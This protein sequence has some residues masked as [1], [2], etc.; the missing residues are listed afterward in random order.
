MHLKLA[1]TTM[2][3]IA[4]VHSSKIPAASPKI[5]SRL[6]VTPEE[7][8][9]IV[10]ELEHAQ[11]LKELEVLI[12][13]LDDDQLDNLEKILVEDEEDTEDTEFGRVKQ[14]LLDMG[15][16][17]QDIEDLKTLAA[18]MVEFLEKIPNIESKLELKAEADLLDN[19]QVIS[20]IQIIQSHES[21]QLYL[22]GLPNKLGPLGF[23]A[24][25]HVLDGADEEEE[26][27]EIVDVVIEPSSIAKIKEM[28][29]KVSESAHFFPASDTRSEAP[30]FRRRR[31][32]GGMMNKV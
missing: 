1:V 14:E 9:V 20:L 30:L 18:L 25:H 23:I 22:L 27:G 16:E 28:E 29:A 13:N 26:E 32:L 15:M 5:D 4:L 3:L 2:W 11:M 8:E 6:H 7:K 12:K 19:V 17:E 31:S 21:F 10:N 24:L